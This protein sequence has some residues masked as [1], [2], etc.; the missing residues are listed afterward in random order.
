MYKY[1][2]VRYIFRLLNLIIYAAIISFAVL[3]IRDDIRITDFMTTIFKDNLMNSKRSFYLAIF[4]LVNVGIILLFKVLS[5][6]KTKALFYYIC[7]FIIRLTFSV[8]LAFITLYFLLYRLMPNLLFD[9]M[10]QIIVFLILFAVYDYL[11]RW[12]IMF[13][14]DVSYFR[15]KDKL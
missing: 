14:L 11:M 12:Q 5:K 3:A 10:T 15:V 6:E 7:D 4:L 8:P 2:P 1:K 13:R 9:A